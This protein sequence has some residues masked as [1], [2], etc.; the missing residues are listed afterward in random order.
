M[1]ETSPASMAAPGEPRPCRACRTRFTP[2]KA[3]GFGEHCGRC[4]KAIRDGRKPGPRLRQPR[5]QAKRAIKSYLRP[6]LA[7]LLTPE[8][9]AQY[10]MTRPGDLLALAVARLLG[11][12]DLEPM[13]TPKEGAAE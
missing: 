3:G 13:K 9:L 1:N 5:G 10:R 6:E 7:D 2:G 12:P 4:Q 11:R 8:L